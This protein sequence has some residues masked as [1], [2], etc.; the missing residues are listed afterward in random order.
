[1]CERARWVSLRIK[2][3]A[4]LENGQIKL[5]FY[6]TLMVFLHWAWY[7]IPRLFRHC[8]AASGCLGLPFSQCAAIRSIS[9]AKI[10]GIDLGT[11]NSVVSVMEGG[12][13]TVISTAEGADYARRL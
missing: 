4:G 1:M 5:N 12:T 2:I 6:T 11:T 3:E 7:Y 9:M 10:I 8:E 13:P